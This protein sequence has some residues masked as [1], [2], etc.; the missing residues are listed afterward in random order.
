VKAGITEQERSDCTHESQTT[1]LA[2]LTE[3][4]GNHRPSEL[5]SVPAAFVCIAV[6]TNK[7]DIG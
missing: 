4:S 2:S 5:V 1:K 7:M 3:F 6:I